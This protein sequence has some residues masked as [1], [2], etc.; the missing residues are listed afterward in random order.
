MGE[1][2]AYI[3]RSM[4]AKCDCGTM[5]NY[6]NVVH[7]HGVYYKGEPLLNANDHYKDE[8][9]SHFGD[10][11]SKKV[12]EDAKKQADEKYKA[13]EGDGFFESVGKG[14]GSFFT[15]AAITLKSLMFNKCDLQTPT[16]WIFTNE[17]HVIDGAPA[18][19]IESKCACLYGGVITIVME[20]EEVPAEEA[21]E[22]ETKEEKE[23]KILTGG[24]LKSEALIK[25]KVSRDKGGS[26]VTQAIVVGMVALNQDKEKLMEI[27]IN[28]DAEGNITSYNWKFI[29]SIMQSDPNNWGDMVLSLYEA[30]T[31]TFMTMTNTKD[32]EKF[33]NCGYRKMKMGITEGQTGETLDMINSYQTLDDKNTLSAYG[34]VPA[35]SPILQGV[36]QYYDRMAAV[37]PAYLDTIEYDDKVFD[38]LRLEMGKANLLHTVCQNGKYIQSNNKEILKI[39]V[40]ENGPV[41]GDF[42]VNIPTYP[43]KKEE[44]IETYT[45][46]NNIEFAGS[47]LNDASKYLEGLSYNKKDFATDT[48][49]TG[50]GL[51]GSQMDKV[52]E[53]VFS[54]SIPYGTAISIGASIIGYARGVTNSEKTE[55]D[56]EK[57][58]K[59]LEF[60]EVVLVLG[61]EVTITKK[62]DGEI[63]VSYI[64]INNDDLQKKL[65]FYNNTINM[66][67]YRDS[68][69]KEFDL[70]KEEYFSL[71]IGKK[72]YTIEEIY[73]G[74]NGTDEKARMRLYILVFVGYDGKNDGWKNK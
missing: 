40:E 17:E 2:K 42:I 54:T 63:S 68:I 74:L 57:V 16:P 52:F 51:V 18:L 67:D 39:K 29:E 46:R 69:I 34:I 3:V 48:I 6:L 58:K 5:E 70:D 12:Y 4:K 43:D 35:Y 31:Y 23:L 50:L 26:A 62:E 53:M 66:D 44:I 22:E 24:T 73:Q 14:I 32:I 1:E 56:A 10:C 15:K 21:A 19:T 38:R 45:L 59:K 49:L 7:G 71:E 30:L 11:N 37:L 36:S 13:E 8:N 28:K 55:E 65:D 41:K 9:L 33:I 72:D 20:V 60:A 47:A 61:M 64:Y 27:M 25:G